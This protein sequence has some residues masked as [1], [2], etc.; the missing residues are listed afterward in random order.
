MAANTALF[1]AV[2]SAAY[3]HLR[4]HAFCSSTLSSSTQALLCVLATLFALARARR[5]RRN[6]ILDD[7]RH[8]QASAGVTLI[9]NVLY[10]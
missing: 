10:V 5:K 8:A 9:A 3:A 6:V 1:V 7:T 2:C 4:H